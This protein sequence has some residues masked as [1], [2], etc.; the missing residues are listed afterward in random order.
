M[1]ARIVCVLIAIS[2]TLNDGQSN[3]CIGG[4]CPSDRFYSDQYDIFLVPGF[5]D[6]KN[7]TAINVLVGVVSNSECAMFCTQNLNCTNFRVYTTTKKCMLYPNGSY[8]IGY[9]FFSKT[10][11]N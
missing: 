5:K 7:T 4:I 8:P 3:S 6:P 1:D 2:F 10:K 9:E 11:L